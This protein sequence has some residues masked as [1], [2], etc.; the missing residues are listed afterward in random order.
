MRSENAMKN[1]IVNI[2]SQL[3]SIILSFLC[4]TIFIQMLGE[5]YLGISGVFSNVLSMLSLAELGI[6][7]AIVFSMYRPLAQNDHK[8]IAALM[9]LYKKAYHTI[10]WI[11]AAVGLAITPFYPY[12]IK[13]ASDLPNL[14]F[15]FLLY[16]FNSS[17]TYFFSYKQSIIVADQKS[18]ICTLY[19]YGFCITQN[20]LQIWILIQTKNFIL[21]LAVQILFSFFTNLFLARKANK[22]YPYLKKYEKEKLSKPDRAAI[23]KNIKA[24]FMHRLGG[25]IVTQT[26]SIL[27]S[28]F[29]GVVIAGIYSNYYLITN[30]LR[31]LTSQL[32]SG[33]TASVGNLG[34]VE[35][36]E[37]SY[38]IYLAINFAG[39]WIFSFCSICLFCLF[40]P[41]I[42]LW[43]RQN[44]LFSEPIVFFISVNFFITGMRQATLLF[45]DALGLFWY[46]RYKSV[47]EAAVNLVSSIVLALLIGKIGI[48][49]GT[50][51]STITV[52]FWVEPL[53]LYRHGFQRSVRSYFNRYAFYT[54]LTFAVGFLTWYCCN[55]IGGTSFY[56]FA[57]K[58]VV[59]LIVPNLLYFLVFSKSKEFQYIKGLI[60]LPSFLKK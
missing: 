15:I 35:N 56:Q 33:M 25:V 37:R 38:D 31:G 23:V 3:V 2:S 13:D 11:V 49:I 51:L 52:C 53:V 48:F 43:T 44:L 12:F 19:Q 41:F 8:K 46:D 17:L 9:A 39:F 27:L 24:L 14:T 47:F 40:N 20:L 4:R 36:R 58:C 1:I 5:T 18:Y 6:G 29:F 59:C 28:A 55:L 26:D 30:T 34:V 50:F 22:M 16:V 21:Y 54:I 7:S 60:H 45:K 10:G 42:L 32:F 57:L